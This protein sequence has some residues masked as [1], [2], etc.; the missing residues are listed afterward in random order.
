MTL[1]Y[2]EHFSWL[3]SCPPSTRNLSLASRLAVVR[4]GLGTASHIFLL[5]NVCSGVRVLGA[6][7]AGVLLGQPIFRCAQN[8]PPKRTLSLQERYTFRIVLVG[9][10]TPRDILKVF[11]SF[12]KLRFSW[13]GQKFGKP[14][15]CPPT[16]TRTWDQPLKRRMLYRLSYGRMSFCVDTF[17]SYQL[18]PYFATKL[19]NKN[20][21]IAILTMVYRG[22]TLTAVTRFINNIHRYGGRIGSPGSM[23]ACMRSCKRGRMRWSTKQLPL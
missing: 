11:S 4:L 15:F 8:C 22:Y 20:G 21:L 19:N 18:E 13:A 10:P 6:R 1:L 12:S 3:Y 14:H 9:V 5:K 17:E 2:H 16:R 23:F 7:R